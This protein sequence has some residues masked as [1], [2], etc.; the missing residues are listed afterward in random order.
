MIIIDPYIN[1]YITVICT[2]H[3]IAT[4]GRYRGE[5][6]DGYQQYDYLFHLFNI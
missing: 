1:G 4:L 6:N 3:A 5:R 2:P